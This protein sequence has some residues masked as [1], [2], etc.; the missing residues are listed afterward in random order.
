MT[1]C[2]CALAAQGEGPLNFKITP[3]SINGLLSQK[4]IRELYQDSSGMLWIRTQDGLH[5]YDGYEVRSFYAHEKGLGALG[6]GS[7]LQITEDQSGTIWLATLGK[8]LTYYDPNSQEFRAANL[9]RNLP[10]KSAPLD[11]S[12]VYTDT[13]GFVWLGYLD[14]DVSRLNTLTK[15]VDLK[16]SLGKLLR[17][18]SAIVGFAEDR[19]SRLWIATARGNLFVCEAF[20]ANC[21]EYFYRPEDQELTTGDG[22]TT[23]ISD[24]RGRIWIGT[25]SSGAYLI[26]PVSGQISQFRHHPHRTSSLSNNSVR[27]IYEDR[28]ERIWIGTDRGL[29][30]LSSKGRFERFG[31]ENV[32]AGQD[33]VISILQD[34]RRNIWIGSYFGLYQG[35]DSKFESFAKSEGLASEI[36]TAFVESGGQQVWVATYNGLFNLAHGDVSLQKASSVIPNIR[37][38]DSRVMSLF[39][40]KPFLWVGYRAHGLDKID[41]ETGHVT[42]F[43]STEYGELESDSIS[44]V[45]RVGKHAVGAASFGG[46]LYIISD[47]TDEISVFRY[48]ESN[49]EGLSSDKIFTIYPTADSEVLLGT[50]MGLSAYSPRRNEVYRVRAENED[51]RFIES[52]QIL[53]I[54][55]DDAANVWLGTQNAGLILWKGEDR[56]AGKNIFTRVNTEPSIPGLTIYAIEVDAA[57]AVWLSTTNGLVRLDPATRQAKIFDQSDG[58]QDNEFNFAASFKDSLNRLYFGGNR[59][60]NRFSPEHIVEDHI[61]PPIKLTQLE[62][63]GVPVSFDTAYVAIPE[64]NLTHRDYFVNFKFSALDF[65]D[66]SRNHYSYKLENFD[67]EWVDIGTRNN[68]T[69]TNL[70]PG[71]YILRVAGANSDGAWNRQGITLPINVLPPPWL[72]WWAFT[73]YLGSLLALALLI[74]KYYDIRGLQMRATEFSRHMQDTAERAMDDLQDQM[75]MEQQLI[76][77]IQQHSLSSLHIVSDLLQ[78]QADS[79]DDEYI[80]ETFRDNQQRCKCLE[81]VEQSIYY[82]VDYLEINF[83]EFL[84]RLFAEFFS[85]IPRTDMEIVIINDTLDTLIPVDIG[86]AAALLCNELLINSYRHAF[87]EATGVQSV[88]VYLRENPNQDGWILEVQDTG[89]GLP[90]SIHPDQPSTTGLDIVQRFTNSL[91]ASMA[92]HRDGGTRFVFEIPRPPQHYS[93]S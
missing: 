2:A 49:P 26:D 11:V 55:E 23:M 4:T 88:R 48:K 6:H 18:P 16:L 51:S 20:S 64:L 77:N 67:S 33:I 43:N 92:V 75:L 17:K 62:I 69:F 68:V 36:V 12:A 39:Y 44:A 79:I 29:N 31:T 47:A 3:S 22:V 89:C 34:E 78:H 82:S 5:R 41:L 74:K 86:T 38:P 65:T 70:P 59:G 19:A 8:G 42:H 73:V 90:E 56:R 85:P 1:A 63:A 84:E 76:Q 9:H 7:A 32:E 57:G 58:L 30:L 21:S 40:S 54:R 35:R 93:G 91:R 15:S 14:G 71:K 25:E 10:G 66:P 81:L 80:L 37:L 24:H 50:I 27:R 83:H 45:A 46:G 72:T 13:S 87:E 52:T 53:A 28:D 60:F 61:P